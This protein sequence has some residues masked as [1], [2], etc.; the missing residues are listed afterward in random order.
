MTLKSRFF[1]DIIDGYFPLNVSL[2]QMLERFG[3][4]AAWVN[5]SFAPLMKKGDLQPTDP[6]P[7]N[8][9]GC[10]TGLINHASLLI[11]KKEDGVN[12]TGV[13]D[14]YWH[15]TIHEIDE[16]LSPYHRLTEPVFVRGCLIEEKVSKMFK[17]DQKNT[18][19]KINPKQ[20]APISELNVSRNQLSIE[21]NVKSGL[22][23][24]GNKKIFGRNVYLNSSANISARNS[25]ICLFFAEVSS[26]PMDNRIFESIVEEK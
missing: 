19:K 22:I 14:W 16:E 12:L 11:S 23:V 25:E 2:G 4:P 24:K 26:M 20:K 1:E 5:F 13:G 3:F 9:D 8:V 7:V 21:T 15:D 6:I 18:R 17:A 10:T